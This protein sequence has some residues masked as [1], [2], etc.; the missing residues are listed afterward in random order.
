MADKIQFPSSIVWAM[1]KFTIFDSNF[2]VENAAKNDDMN[3]TNTI[4]RSRS[5]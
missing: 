2:E 1:S 3:K 4:D 5:F